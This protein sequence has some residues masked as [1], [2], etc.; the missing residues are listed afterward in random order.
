MVDKNLKTFRCACNSEIDQRKGISVSSFF[1]R[2]FVQLRS[3]LRTWIFLTAVKMVTTFSST[4]LRLIK[5]YFRIFFVSLNLCGYLC[6]MDISGNSQVQSFCRC[7]SIALATK[8]LRVL[9]L[10][11]NDKTRSHLVAKPIVLQTN[12]H[13]T[14]RTSIRKIS[15]NICKLLQA[16]GTNSWNR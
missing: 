7:D 15:M 12:E 10:G 14:I 5:Q 8:W 1:F 13:Q 4:I 16:I 6:A 2:I 3:K 9:S 11:G